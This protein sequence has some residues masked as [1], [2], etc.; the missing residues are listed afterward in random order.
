MSSLCF[1]KQP[2]WKCNQVLSNKPS[3]VAWQPNAPHAAAVISN[4]Y[5][6]ELE[7]YSYKYIIIIYLF[8]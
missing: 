7:M 3:G 2:S 4:L 5:S 1:H 8:T 6:S